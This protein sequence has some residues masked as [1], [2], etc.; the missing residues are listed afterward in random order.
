[1]YNILKIVEQN[2][3]T[4]YDFSDGARQIPWLRIAIF[5][6]LSISSSIGLNSPGTE[7]ITAVL[8]SISILIGFSL[9][10][11]FYLV[12]N[13][14][15][16]F[17]YSNQQQISNDSRE[18][19][20]RRKRLENLGL[21]L[22]FNVSFFTVIALIIAAISVLMMMG[23]LGI[24]V[25]IINDI[26]NVL[27][28]LGCVQVF[29]KITTISAKIISYFLI[30]F[31]YFLIAESLFTYYRIVHRSYFYFRGRLQLTQ[32]DTK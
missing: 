11:L 22:F 14:V 28:R 17:Q 5:A 26:T 32:S 27:S 18:N 15:V 24:R 20:L 12:S 7:L 10:L 4:Y 21:E 9:S 30:S 13:P 8:V 23:E 25:N 31:W 2:Y 3:K 16:P 29:I 19:D 6:A 1:M